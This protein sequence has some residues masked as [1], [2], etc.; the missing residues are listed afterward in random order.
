MINSLPVPS[1]RKKMREIINAVETILEC[2]DKS[3]SAG[4]GKLEGS[5]NEHLYQLYEL[6]A[7]EIS[8]VEGGCR[9][10]AH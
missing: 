3:S 7:H 8:Q 4:I 9:F 2:K 5:I 6:S 1:S 10:D